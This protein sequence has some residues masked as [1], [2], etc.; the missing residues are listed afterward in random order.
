M[1]FVEKYIQAS[2]AR[3]IRSQ[4]LTALR[5]AKGTAS[6]STKKMRRASHLLTVDL[7]A[8]LLGRL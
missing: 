7:M 2:M 8:Y 1:A 6:E 3:S 5:N 4:R